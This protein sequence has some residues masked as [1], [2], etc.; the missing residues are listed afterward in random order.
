MDKG[1]RD[2]FGAHFTSPVDV[3]MI[4]GPTIVEPWRREIEGATIL[5]QL[6][7]LLSRIQHFKVLDP[8]CGSGNFLYIAYRELKRLEARIIDRMETE[9]KKE[10]AKAGDMRISFLSAHNFYGIDVLP[11]AVELAKVTMMIARKLAIDELH[12]SEEALPLDNLDSN[13]VASDAL[14]QSEPLSGDD[15]K[16][17]WRRPIVTRDGKPQLVKWPEVDVIIG[18]P[19]FSRLLKNP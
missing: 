11:F 1:E 18:N 8:A 16:A 15:E 17:N 6:R 19:P 2:A 4:V 7:Q 12:I 9:F 10:A 14:I 5:K 3:M 13:F